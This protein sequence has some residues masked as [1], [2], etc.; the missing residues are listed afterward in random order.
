MGL[1]KTRKNCKKVK[2]KILLSKT[3]VSLKFLIEKKIIN[4]ERKTPK[5]KEYNPIKLAKIYFSF[6]AS[7][8][9]GGI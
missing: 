6:R 3:L 1:I 4:N 5:Y 2:D 8:T 9:S 7:L